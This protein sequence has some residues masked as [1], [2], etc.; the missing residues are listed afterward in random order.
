MGT[1]F[2]LVGDAPHGCAIVTGVS[3]AERS[4]REHQVIKPGDELTVWVSESRFAA[5][6]EPGFTPEEALTPH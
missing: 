4:M 3:Q 2:L 5:Y 1:T 6:T